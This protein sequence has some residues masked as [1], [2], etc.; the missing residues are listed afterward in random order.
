MGLDISHDAWHG[1]Y[2][3]FMRYRQKL[4]E[5]M[6]LPP[7]DLMEGYYSEGNNNPMV[8]LNYRYP[9]GDE[10]DVSHLR[11][12][13]KQ[14]P[15]KWEC[16]K[17]NPIHELLCHSDCDGYINWKACGKI[18]DELEKLLPLLD[19][20]GAGHIGNYKEKTEKFIKG[21]RLAHSKKEKLKFH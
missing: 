10:L 9:K 16:L 19:E 11:R 1:A 4:A 15:I 6:G 2:S 13:F 3:S 7:L 12:I 18:A 17:P 21:L 20:D 14:M 8:L 5:V